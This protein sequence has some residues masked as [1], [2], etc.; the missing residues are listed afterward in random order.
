KIGLKIDDKAVTIVVIATDA[1]AKTLEKVKG[2]QIAL[3]DVNDLQVIKNPT[4][5]LT[6]IEE[7]PVQDNSNEKK[8][9]EELILESINKHDLET[10]AMKKIK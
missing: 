5:Y 9:L 7:I 8:T 2:V 4:L 6:N 3:Q 1:K 10:T